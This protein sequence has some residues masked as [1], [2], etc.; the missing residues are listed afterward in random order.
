MY[1]FLWARLFELWCVLI[2]GC[3]LVFSQAWATFNSL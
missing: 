3:G 2:K 1:A